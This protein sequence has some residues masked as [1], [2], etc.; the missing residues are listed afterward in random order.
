MARNFLL[1]G[2]DRI[3]AD[4]GVSKFTPQGGISKTLDYSDFVSEVKSGRI[5]KVTLD[6]SKIEFEHQ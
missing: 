3:S 1:M 4:D 6:G 5:A 2:S